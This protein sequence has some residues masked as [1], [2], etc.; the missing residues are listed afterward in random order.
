MSYRELEAV[1]GPRFMTVEVL[2]SEE[3]H[4]AKPWALE[5]FCG[6]KVDYPMGKTEPT[7]PGCREV[8]DLPKDLKGTPETGGYPGPFPTL[9]GETDG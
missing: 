7:C 8:V 5:T 6:L 4:A 2:G 1:D 9:N 3:S